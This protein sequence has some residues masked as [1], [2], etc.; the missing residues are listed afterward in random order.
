[1]IQ[2][3]LQILKARLG[4]TSDVRDTY[5]TKRIEGV[6]AELKNINGLVL[7]ESDANLLMFIV[8]YATWQYE[9]RDELG[10][11]PRHLQFRLH[12]L[13]VSQYSKA[14]EEGGE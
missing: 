12:N 5:L 13:I 4:I 2:N 6:I 10:T 7:D 8:D 1:M 3:A 14:N 11:M 9:N